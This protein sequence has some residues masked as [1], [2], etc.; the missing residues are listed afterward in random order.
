MGGAL[1]PEVTMTKSLPG[2]GSGIVIIYYCGRLVWLEDE[3]TDP[4]AIGARTVEALR[5]IAEPRGQAQDCASRDDSQTTL[6]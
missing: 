2:R 5:A 6:H 4:E 1:G 3:L